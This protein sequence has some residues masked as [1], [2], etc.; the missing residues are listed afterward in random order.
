[1]TVLGAVVIL[2]E[3]GPPGQGEDVVIAEGKALPVIRR[4]RHVLDHLAAA[5]VID[6]FEFLGAEA[7]LQ[8]RPKPLL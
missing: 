7:F 3:T 2:D 6:E 8:N 4:H 1:M 5:N